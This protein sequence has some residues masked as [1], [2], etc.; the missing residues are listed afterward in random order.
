MKVA[1]ILLLVCLLFSVSVVCTAEDVAMVVSG[2]ASAKLGNESWQ[3]ELAEMLPAGVLLKV[4]SAEILKLIHLANDKEYEIP[5]DSEVKI[6]TDSIEG[7]DFSGKPIEIVT[8]DLNLGEGMG[9]QT[10]AAYLDR[11][12]RAREEV[13]MKEKIQSL[14]RAS[15]QAQESGPQSEIINNKSLESFDD[16]S[17]SSMSGLDVGMAN[18]TQADEEN[19]PANPIL[20]APKPQSAPA[21]VDKAKDASSCR[22][23]KAETA[24]KLLVFAVPESIAA[25]FTR[26]DDDYDYSSE[27][28]AG[29]VN[30][31]NKGDWVEFFVD[32]RMDEKENFSIVFASA[33]KNFEV[34]LCVIET[35]KAKM[36]DALGLEKQGLYHQAAGTW[37]ELAKRLAI[38]EAALNKHLE[39]LAGKIREK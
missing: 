10:G 33:E 9:Q 27:K 3:V 2:A 21:P 36:S 6:A 22:P 39:R 28:K 31:A 23:K 20:E 30:F 18:S 37:M 4:G 15:S 29:I 7:I 25:Q 8:N 12:T 16:V 35:S 11:N 14:F 5:A 34:P 26:K 38:S 19:P 24:Q 17:D 13:V 1:R 32:G